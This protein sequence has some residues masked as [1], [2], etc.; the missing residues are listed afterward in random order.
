VP[1]LDR[2]AKHGPTYTQ[3]PTTS[4][5]SPT[6]SCFPT[7]RNHHPNGFDTIAGSAAGF[8]S[9]AGHVPPEN[10]TIATLLREAG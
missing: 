9:Y 10:A 2:L 5:C 7:G 6:R 8:P 3:W 1:T 4:V